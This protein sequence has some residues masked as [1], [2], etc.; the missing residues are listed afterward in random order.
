ME[1]QKNHLK[2]SINLGKKTKE[3]SSKNIKKNIKKEIKETKKQ[4]NSN[5]PQ[6]KKPKN[7][8]YS[9]TF[10]SQVPDMNKNLKNNKIN[11][12]SNSST[13]TSSTIAQN[14]KI[15]VNNNLKNDETNKNN[16]NII[17]HRRNSSLQIKKKEE[18]LTKNSK[19]ASKK[20]IEDVK[21]DKKNINSDIKNIIVNQSK[22]I[23]NTE[24]IND[25]NTNETLNQINE[26]NLMETLNIISD[27]QKQFENSLKENKK[28]LEEIKRLI[29][30]NLNVMK[31]IPLSE[32]QKKN[33]TNDIQKSSDLRIKNYEMAFYYIKTSLDEIKL[34]LENMV[35][36]EEINPNEFII[37]TALNKSYGNLSN[38][39]NSFS[40]SKSEE[41]EKE[42]LINE[43]KELNN[44]EENKKENKIEEKRKSNVDT[45]FQEGIMLENI[46][47]MPPKNSGFNYQIVK[48]MTRMRSKNFA[49]MKHSAKNKESN[50]KEVDKNIKIEE[51]INYEN[52]IQNNDNEK[53]NNYEKSKEEL[54][55]ECIIF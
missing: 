19:K 42:Q 23:S 34:L 30:N 15:K 50:F 27:I 16:D 10:I 28:P 6:L 12:P 36:Q 7:K 43:K 25:L 20:N 4:D 55:K 14:K 17:S 13:I 24:I 32:N 18:K 5:P 39:N 37:K 35:E 49:V 51:K 31:Y 52:V 22:N 1:K 3:E 48:D 29:D 26:F 54:K 41:E 38:E 46:V 53:L 33:I 47:V 11:I 9:Q 8:I 44:K 40:S 45:D 21:E 2:K